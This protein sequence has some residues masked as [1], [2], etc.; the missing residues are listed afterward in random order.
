MGRNRYF[1]TDGIR[2]QVGKFPIVPE[3]IFKLGWSI[4]RVLSKNGLNTVVIGKDTRISSHMLEATL[5]AGLL[6]SGVVS[7]MFSGVIPTPAIAYLTRVFR[8]MAGVVIS[9]SHNPFYDNGVKCFSMKG[10]KLSFD[11]EK[12][13]ELEID[14][15]KTFN[16]V[17]DSVGFN[18]SSYIVDAAIRYIEFC[19]ATFPSDLTLRDFKIVL[20]CANGASYYV[21]PNVLCELGATVQCVNCQPNGININKECGTT[22]IRQ[23]KNLVIQEKAHLGI[24]YDGD[25]DRVIM[26]D[27]LG[28]KVDG[29]QILYIIARDRYRSS[30]LFGGVVGTQ[31]SNMGLELSLK[32]LGVPFVRSNVGDRSIFSMMQKKRWYIGGENSGHIILLDKSTAGD[33]IIACLQVLLAMVNNQISL[34]DLCKGI[35]LFPQVLLNVPFVCS[36]DPL[37]YSVIRNIIQEVKNELGRDGRVFLRMSGTEPCIRI[38]VE[39]KYYNQVTD[40]ANKIVDVLKNINDEF[41]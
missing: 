8:A 15:R 23:L 40:L 3:F 19:K 17:V 12:A 13:I 33:A 39:G 6:S 4:G 25:A 5:V 29:D 9:A 18:K 30:Q 37:K 16:Y 32:T 11:F 27:H 10:V 35:Y 28:N 24:A 22:D 34:Y 41:S 14:N 21:A 2:G 1:G 20:D 36:G 38:M 7:V 26:V 31:M